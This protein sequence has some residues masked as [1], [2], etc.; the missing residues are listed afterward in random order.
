MRI[1]LLTRITTLALLVIV[2]V[3]AAS[4]V[5]SL[6]KLDKAY[7]AAVDYQ[8]YKEE[9]RR[10]IELPIQQ[11]LFTGDATLLSTI[12]DNIEQQLHQTRDNTLLP[13]EVKK[14]ASEKLLE[15]NDSTLP[16]L[17]SA[18]KLADPQ[19]LLRNNERELSGYL[20]SAQQYLDKAPDT[21]SH[22]LQQYR[23]HIEQIATNLIALIHAR[24]NYFS[25]NDAQALNS[26]HH[27]LKTMNSA[28]DT[29]RTLSPLGVYKEDDSAGEDDIGDLLGWEQDEESEQREDIGGEIF[30]EVF[31]LLNRYPKELDNAQKFIRQKQQAERSAEAD[32]VGLQQALTIFEEQLA[33]QYQSIQEG[34]YLLLAICLCLI[35]LIAG[36]MAFIKHHLSAIL[37]RTCEYVDQLAKG[38]LTSEMRLNSRINEVT[39]L[40]DSINSLQAFFSRLLE[41][42][43]QETGALLSLQD[44]MNQGVRSLRNIVNEQQKGTEDSA[45]R[46]NQLTASYIQV[47]DSASSASNATQRARTIGQEGAELMGN[48]SQVVL[49]LSQDVESTSQALE[50]LKDDAASIKN[51]L[52]VIQGFAEQTNLL[53]LNAAI[54]AA[55]AGDAGRGF[56]VV[57]DEVRNLA[58]NTAASADQIKE[59]TDKLNHATNQAVER[60]Q[61]Q[62]HTAQATV[63]TAEQAK[64]SID[65]I[66]QAI[67]E[68]HEMN[69]LIANTTEEQSQVTA[70][71]SELMENNSRLAASSSQEAQ[72]NRRYAKELVATSNKL[73]SLVQQFR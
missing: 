5:W 53:A 70:E 56:A 62:K 54:E 64:Q 67:A 33:E 3:L 69:T 1:A 11:Y 35:I 49:Q 8:Q 4:I 39:S 58:S 59:I 29:L 16:Q 6:N 68:I 40:K 72:N 27:Y 55:R 32:V 46:M 65:Q 36:S 73:D 50:T 18:G 25:S 41:N 60:M 22:L 31:S 57:A 38:E 42:I 45:V 71:I 48:A 24:Q 2:A 14:Q 51:V 9:T 15:L 30:A 63:S 44:E 20:I 19:A 10:S 21:E 47:A 34:V 26:I 52:A 61:Q 37:G 43:G 66:Q 23:S 12:A 7:L 28:A 13:A 17:R